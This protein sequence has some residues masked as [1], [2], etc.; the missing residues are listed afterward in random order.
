MT[1]DAFL[2]PR[3]R[4]PELRRTEF[5]ITFTVTAFTIEK[6]PPLVGAGALVGNDAQVGQGSNA[7]EGAEG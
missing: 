1:A 7:A 6:L 2:G 4:V 3:E 5:R